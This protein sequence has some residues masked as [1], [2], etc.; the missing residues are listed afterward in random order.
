[1]TNEFSVQKW[2][3]LARSY[4]PST[5]VERTVLSSTTFGV[6]VK[7]NELPFVNALIML[8][9]MFNYT[10]LRYPED[11]P[12]EGSPIEALILQWVEH[13]W[14]LSLMQLSPRQLV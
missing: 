3:E 11:F 1:M 12:V 9:Y 6:F 14:N 2:N 4:P 13:S 8:P 5:R 7:V 10:S